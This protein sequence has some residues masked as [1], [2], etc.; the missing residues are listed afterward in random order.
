MNDKLKAL[1]EKEITLIC[2]EMG[3][4]KAEVFELDEDGLI[5][6]YDVIMDIEMEEEMKNPSK[7]SEKA[8][9]AAN[10]LSTIGE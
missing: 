6:V 3:L 4:S 1:D 10:I 2:K 5:E 8:V 9:L 7:M